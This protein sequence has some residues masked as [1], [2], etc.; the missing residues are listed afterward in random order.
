MVTTT[1]LFWL[2]NAAQRIDVSDTMDFYLVVLAGVRVNP[3]VSPLDTPWNNLR[4][5]GSRQTPWDGEGGG[6]P[7]RSL[8]RYHDVAAGTRL[9][10]IVSELWCQLAWPM[11]SLGSTRLL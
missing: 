8:R 10:L 1:L 2:I 11:S 4:R 3:L 6:V 5:P 7:W 9:S